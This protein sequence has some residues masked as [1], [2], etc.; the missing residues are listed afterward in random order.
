MLAKFRNLGLDHN[1]A[2]GI[3]TVS[4]IEFLMIIFSL[5]K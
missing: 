3:S 4:L 2:V 1:L 5:V